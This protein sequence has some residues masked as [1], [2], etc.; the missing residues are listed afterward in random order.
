MI[1]YSDPEAGETDKADAKLPAAGVGN[2]IVRAEEG[3]ETGNNGFDYLP[4]LAYPNNNEYV[5]NS[6]FAVPEPI[7]WVMMLMGFAGLGFAGYRKAKGRT[8]L[9]GA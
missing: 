3:P 5:G 7:T 4:G 2:S 9:S 1:F 6:D 8:T